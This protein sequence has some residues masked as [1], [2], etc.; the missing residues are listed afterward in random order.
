M[1]K[2]E[3]TGRYGRCLFRTVFH[4]L[5]RVRQS[6]ALQSVQQ[7]LRLVLTSRKSPPDVDRVKFAGTF[8]VPADPQESLRTQGAEVGSRMGN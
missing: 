7:R 1:E 8:G 2:L 3:V 6:E 5:S 4:L